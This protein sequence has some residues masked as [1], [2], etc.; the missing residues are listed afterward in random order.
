M[1]NYFVL[2]KDLLS[3]ETEKWNL[4]QLAFVGEKADE[5]HQRSNLTDEE[6]K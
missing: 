4:A 6:W 3:R 5:E 2:F 1:T